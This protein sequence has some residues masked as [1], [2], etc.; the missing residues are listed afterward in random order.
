MV[1]VSSFLFFVTSYT[2]WV[3]HHHTIEEETMFPAFQSVPGVKSGSLQP[4]INQHHSFSHGLA[5]LRT[6]AT[7][8]KPTS[9]SS[10][11]FCEIIQAFAKPLRDHLADEIQ[12]LWDMDSVE[13]N[14]PA[15]GKLLEIYQSCEAEAGNQ[16]KTVVPPMVLGLCDRTFEGGNEWPKMPAGSAYFVHYLF[17][18]KHRR[19]WKFLPCD[20]W[21]NPRPLAR[22]GDDDSAQGK[23]S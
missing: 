14:S 9:Y 19:A 16:D 6:Y 23:R 15:S 4:N 5:T 21:R 12:T 11:R 2:D 22:I 7:E 20:T 17:G 1:E 8:T 10:A 18:W 3:I 13:A